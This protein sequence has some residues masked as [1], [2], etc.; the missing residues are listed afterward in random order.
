MSSLPNY[1]EILGLPRGAT[2]EQI[3]DAAKTL[4]ERFPEEARDPATNV[5]FRLLV[6]DY[7]IL[8]DP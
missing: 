7:E 3:R 6:Q 1:Y 8:S 5:A 2:T 4:G